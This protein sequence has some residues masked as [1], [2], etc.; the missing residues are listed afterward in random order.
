[1]ATEGANVYFI[2]MM[3]DKGRTV[4][5]TGVTNSLVR[6]V[7][8]HR[9][10]EIEGFTKR[11][12]TNRLVYHEQFH[13][14]CDAI[15]REKQVKGWS[16]EKKEALINTMNPKWHDLAATVLGL[17]SA[18]PTQWQGGRGWCARDPSTGS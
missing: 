8:Q 13:N 15:A 1:M 3:T 10:G 6:R 2:Y 11:Y 7:S 12:N 17:G 9:R 16:R 4:L 18:P 5:Y 14:A